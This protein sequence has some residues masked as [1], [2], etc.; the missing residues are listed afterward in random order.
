[1][2]V[3]G[4]RLHP[5]RRAHDPRSVARGEAY[6]QL[7]RPMANSVVRRRKREMDRQGSEDAVRVRRQDQ[8]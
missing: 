3:A 2:E 1:V 8:D 7:P 6:S 4:A 5:V